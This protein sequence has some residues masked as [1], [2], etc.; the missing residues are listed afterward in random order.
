MNVLLGSEG[1]FWGC[2]SL[3]QIVRDCVPFGGCKGEFV[4]V[5]VCLQNPS[6]LRFTAVGQEGQLVNP[7]GP[8]TSWGWFSRG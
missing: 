5:V 3:N 4:Q 7:E 1:Y 6:R 2:F 8:S